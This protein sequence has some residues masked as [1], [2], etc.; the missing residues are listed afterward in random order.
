MHL[1]MWFSE[2][3]QIS[4]AAVCTLCIDPACIDVEVCAAVEKLFCAAANLFDLDDA[5]AAPATFKAVD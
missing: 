5:P 1:S 2:C 4:L 3:I